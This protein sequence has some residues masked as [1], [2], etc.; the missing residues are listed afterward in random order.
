MAA[1]AE[2]TL[3][4]SFLAPASNKTFSMAGC[5]CKSAECRG[6]IGNVTTLPKA[7]AKSVLTDFP[8]LLDEEL[9]AL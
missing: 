7:L 2:I 8:I 3:D 9:R 4:Y 5:A 1:G 6:A